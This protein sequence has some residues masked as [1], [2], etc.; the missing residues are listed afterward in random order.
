MYHETVVKA[1][2]SLGLSEKDVQTYIFL[3]KKGP[4]SSEEIAKALKMDA[5][6]IRRCLRNLQ[7]KGIV[8]TVVEPA[9][10]VAVPFGRVIDMIAK[11]KKL[12]ARTIQRNKQKILSIW[13]S[14]NQ[15]TS[16][17]VR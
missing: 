11:T 2:M 8:C 1:L 4:K 14:L 10:F 15:K 17:E 7:E 5:R 6:Q 3:G 13:K 12:Q 16:S 9:W